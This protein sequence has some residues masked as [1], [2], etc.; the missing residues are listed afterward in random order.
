MFFSLLVT[1][2]QKHQ[3]TKSW[4]FKLTENYDKSFLHFKLTDML[5]HCYFQADP[6][7]T[8]QPQTTIMPLMI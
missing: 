4:H 6:K 7:M 8:V 2:L 3:L 1:V 5:R